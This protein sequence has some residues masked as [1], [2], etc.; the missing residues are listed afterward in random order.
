MPRPK[1]NNASSS[2]TD[3]TTLDTRVTTPSGILGEGDDRLVDRANAVSCSQDLYVAAKCSGD[4]DA[5]Y[6]EVGDSSLTLTCAKNHAGITWRVNVAIEN[7]GTINWACALATVRT[8][9]DSKAKRSWQNVTISG[10]LSL[11]E[12]SN[13]TTQT[14]CGSD[15]G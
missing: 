6:Q 10:R 1:A 15:S 9:I 14:E 11:C 7:N 4:A 3:D 13:V 8:S 2:S 12:D 5:S